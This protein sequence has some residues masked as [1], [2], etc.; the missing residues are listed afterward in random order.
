MKNRTFD[1]N[2]FQ[3]RILLF[4]IA[5]VA[6]SCRNK[7]IDSANVL[8]AYLS[9]PNLKRV[10]DTLIYPFHG[11]SYKVIIDSNSLNGKIRKIF[12]YLANNPSMYAGYFKFNTDGKLDKYYFMA[13]DGEHD[14]YR[15][16]YNPVKAKYEEQGNAYVDYVAPNIIKDTA[17]DYTFVFSTFPRK[18]VE[19]YYSIDWAHYNKMNLAAWE[20]VP[21]ITDGKIIL[22]K[23]QVDQGI[24]IKV[25][26]KDLGVRLNG[27]E[28]SRETIDT[29]QFK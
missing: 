17:N 19:A 6:C 13:G 3:M 24:L 2:N 10:Q 16:T 20:T 12:G 7:Q 25:K 18:E 28:K 23:K 22:T 29:I 15:I 8:E 5:L 4:L 1:L 14:L 9:N 27:L 11:A 21:F 26:A